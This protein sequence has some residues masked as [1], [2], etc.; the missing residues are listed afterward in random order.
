MSSILPTDEPHKMFVED[1]L[2]LEDYFTWRANDDHIGARCLN[3]NYP[4]DF[5]PTFT[6][7][8]DDGLGQIVCIETERSTK[9][10]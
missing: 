5:V 1:D 9:F 3:P 10:V 7:V 6:T 4:Q 8:P 2:D